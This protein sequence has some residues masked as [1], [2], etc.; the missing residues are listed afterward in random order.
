M[1][2]RKGYNITNQFATYYLT[3]RISGWADI[4]TRR[5]CRDI[6]IDSFKYCQAHKGLNLNAYVIMSNHVHIIASA[7]RNSKGL[8]SII[9]DFKKYTSVTLIKWIKYN[10]K[11]SRSDWLA[12]IFQYH[13]KYIK[14]NEF[15]KVWHSSNHPKLLFGPIFTRRKLD[16]IHNNPVAAKIVSRPSDYIYSSARNYA[17]VPGAILD[18]DIID[19]GVEQ[20]YVYNNEI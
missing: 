14:N 16:Y 7:K 17:G 18:V 15:Y 2:E 3:F 10:S 19:F 11:E 4:F 8:S 1:A 5:E 6:I 12:L 9:R 13:A 20:G